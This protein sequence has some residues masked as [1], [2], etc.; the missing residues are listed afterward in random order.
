[1]L[2]TRIFVS[3]Y[4][5]IRSCIISFRTCIWII[6]VSCCYCNWKLSSC[7]CWGN[8][9]YCYC[10]GSFNWYDPIWRNTINSFSFDLPYYSYY[11]W[12]IIINWLN[13]TI[14]IIKIP[15]NEYNT[16]SSVTL[17]ILSSCC[18]SSKCII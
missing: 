13:L 18:S 10:I 3:S 9:S 11:R 17:P 4:Y 12:I 2:D 1:M 15:K 8:W 6:F 14:N 7:I 16:T 5:S